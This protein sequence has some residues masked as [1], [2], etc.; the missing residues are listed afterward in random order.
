MPLKSTFFGDGA[1]YNLTGGTVTTNSVIT[2][3]GNESQLNVSNEDTLSHITGKASYTYSG[4]KSSFTMDEINP[5]TLHS[6]AVFDHGSVTYSKKE[7]TGDMTGGRITSLSATDKATV[8]YSGGKAIFQLHNDID[9]Y[10]LID[11]KAV[12]S[13]TNSNN[14]FNQYG[15]AHGSIEGS[16]V[17]G[18]ATITMTGDNNKYLQ[19]GDSVVG[20]D[21]KITLTNINAT[22]N[23][24]SL[25]RH[26]ENATLRDQA[27]VNIVTAQNNRFHMYGSDNNRWDT[28]QNPTIIISATV[29]LNNAASEGNYFLMDTGVISSTGDGKNTIN[30][31]GADSSM[32]VFTQTGGRVSTAARGSSAANAANINLNGA[33]SKQNIFELTN[34]DPNSPVTNEYAFNDYDVIIG[35][36]DGTVNDISTHGIY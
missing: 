14:T 20:G 28:T 31:N 22:L 4:E 25:Y 26:F 12:L 2:F 3:S 5:T 13:F 11:E 24:N 1:Q 34:L 33:R 19:H 15:S 21:A 8:S 18:E 29:N 32:N 10:G 17:Q 27:E 36:N 7:S 9:S 30:I 6:E 35:S 16:K 23:N